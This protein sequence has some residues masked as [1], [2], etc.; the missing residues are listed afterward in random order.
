MD[1][2]DLEREHHGWAFY[3]WNSNQ[4]TARRQPARLECQQLRLHGSLTALTLKILS[5]STV[6]ETGAREVL[7]LSPLSARN[8]NIRT[9]TV[10]ATSLH[11]LPQN[12]PNSSQLPGATHVMVCFTSPHKHKET[13]ARRRQE[14]AGVVPPEALLRDGQGWG[15][16][17][18][19]VSPSYKATD[20]LDKLIVLQITNVPARSVATDVTAIVKDTTSLY[21]AATQNTGTDPYIFLEIVT[22]S[23]CVES[24]MHAQPSP[25]RRKN[26]Q[27]QS[28]RGAPP[29]LTP[30]RV[31]RN[32]AGRSY[33][34]ATATT[35]NTPFEHFASSNRPDPYICLE[36]ACSTDISITKMRGEAGFT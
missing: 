2:G 33:P 3:I 19:T 11:P 12:G 21:Q 10:T 26:R 36:S 1:R 8:G 16:G 32:A 23:I 25:W 9:P 35:S 29:T 31:S 24:T 27:C 28:N 4:K 14:V 15:K 20:F 7:K 5:R 17:R 6:V 34:D 30:R 18:L 22:A 13:A